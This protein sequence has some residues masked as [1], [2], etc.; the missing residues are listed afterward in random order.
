MLRNWAERSELQMA[1]EGLGR[2]CIEGRLCLRRGE[3]ID[4]GVVEAGRSAKMKSRRMQR[5]TR[6]G[7]VVKRKKFAAFISTLVL[8]QG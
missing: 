5:Q 6:F 7:F 4:S 3:S 2:I 1:I 8:V